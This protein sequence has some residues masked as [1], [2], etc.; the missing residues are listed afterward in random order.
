M[1]ANS[2]NAALRDLEY[3]WLLF[4]DDD[5]LVNQH[6]LDHLATKA[7]DSVW[8]YP[9]ATSTAS[10]T[11]I[12]LSCGS[13]KVIE[14]KPSYECLPRVSMP[15]EMPVEWCGM[16]CTA[17]P[18]CVKGKLEMPFFDHIWIDGQQIYEDVRFCERCN[19]SGIPIIAHWDPLWTR[20]LSRWLPEPFFLQGGS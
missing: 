14:D 20:H 3:D 18:A 11:S 5:V 13:R 4:I 1:L 17:I 10:G 19:A 12:H 9:Y 16:G 6:V 2:R 7:P 15:F 8:H